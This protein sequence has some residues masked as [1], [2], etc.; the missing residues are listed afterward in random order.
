MKNK[1]GYKETDYFHCKYCDWKTLKFYI[2]K[3]GKIVDGNKR[4]MY[5]VEDHH[6]Q[7]YEKIIAYVRKGDLWW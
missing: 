3:R 6:W 2:N 4:I 7:I 5:H 1:F